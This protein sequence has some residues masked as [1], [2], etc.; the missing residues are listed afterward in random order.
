MYRATDKSRVIRPELCLASAH[1]S[2]DESTGKEKNAKKDSLFLRCTALLILLRISRYG[3]KQRPAK[4]MIKRPGERT[5]M[6]CECQPGTIFLKAKRMY[7][8][9]SRSLVAGNTQPSDSECGGRHPIR[10]ST[11]VCMYAQTDMERRRG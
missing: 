9:Q 10:V 7:A 6:T 2:Q 11:C 4:L 5:N 3:A 1:I 8:V